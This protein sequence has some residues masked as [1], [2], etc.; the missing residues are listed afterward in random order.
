[1]MRNVEW[2]DVGWDA[3]TEGPRDDESFPPLNDMEAQRAWLGGFGAARVEASD[4]G[5][6]VDEALA[7]ALEGRAALLRQLR[8]HRAGCAS[9]TAQ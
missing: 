8:S 6:S 9:W 1:M 2:F 4:D 5:D 3:L 7:R